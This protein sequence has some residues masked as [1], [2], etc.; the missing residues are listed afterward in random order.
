MKPGAYLINTARGAIV[1]ELALAAALREGRLAGA[2][3]DV[4]S[5]EPLEMDHPLRA[6]PNVVLTPHIGFPTD[7]GYAQFA[8]AACEALFRY[9]DGASR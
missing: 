5:R 2:G 7:H 6:A 9:L 1:D 8:E 4:F 3:L